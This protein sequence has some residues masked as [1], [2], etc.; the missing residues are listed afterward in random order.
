MLVVF[1]CRPQEKK[2]LK[3]EKIK[4]YQIKNIEYNILVNND[5]ETFD[6]KKIYENNADG[7]G[8]TYELTKNITIEENAGDKGSWFVK[9]ELA[10]NSLYS[11]YKEFYQSGKIKSKGPKFKEDCKI[12]IWYDFDEIGK[13][14]KELDLDK[15]FKITIEDI[16]EYLKDNEADLY[17]SFTSINRSYEEETKKAKWS[18]I[19]RGIYKDKPGMFMIEID[20]SRAEIVKVVKILGKEGEKEFFLKNRKLF[21]EIIV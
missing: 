4:H 9:N 17:S 14:I 7:L 2:Q 12:G 10:N 21:C 11:T 6:I 16:I 5:F 20:D 19:Y 8:K 3:V 1:S 13:L 15:P 18:L